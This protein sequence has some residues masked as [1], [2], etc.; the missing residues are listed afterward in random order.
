MAQTMHA[1]FNIL[2]F[3]WWNSA[4]TT[5]ADPDPGILVRFLIFYYG[6]DV[7]GSNWYVAKKSI[8][9]DRRYNKGKTCQL[10]WLFQQRL[11]LNKNI[12][13]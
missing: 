12:Q 2:L 6:S 10:F 4:S 11:S 5:E 7:E 3:V 9:I 1:V 13:K 8:R